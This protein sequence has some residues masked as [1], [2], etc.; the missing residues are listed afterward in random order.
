MT[1]VFRHYGRSLVLIVMC[2][3]LAIFL[4]GDV[5]GMRGNRGGGNQLNF[6]IGTAFGQSVYQRDL[7]R[8]EQDLLIAGAFGVGLP[9]PDG[10]DQ[11]ERAVCAYL[12]MEEARRAGVRFSL[13]EA[14]QHVNRFPPETVDNI[15]VHYSQSLEGMYSAVAR[16]GAALMFE[17][18]QAESVATE[19]A[20]RLE[21]FYRDQYQSAQCK[22]AAIDARGLLAAVPAPDDAE[23]TAHFEEA[24]NREDAHT[25]DALAF[26]YLLKDRV[27]LEFLT[28]DPK[29]C[30]NTIKV[31]DR[32]LQRYYDEHAAQRYTRPA[33]TS[34]PVAPNQPPPTELI[35]FAECKERVRADLRREKA[36]AEAQR[37]MNEVLHEAR[38]PWDSAA[39][40]EKGERQAPAASAQLSF[41]A[42]RAKFSQ[43]YTV[44]R[45]VTELEDATA[46]SREPGIGQSGELLNQRR[47]PISALA[48]RV[49]GIAT[50]TEGDSTP[51]LKLNEPKLAMTFEFSGRKQESYQFY[52]YRVVEAVAKGPPASLADVRD[53]AIENLKTRRAYEL[54]GEH[55]RKIAERA[56]TIGLEAAIAEDAELKT[57]LSEADAK[58]AAATQAASAPA[59]PAT[60]YAKSLEVRPDTPISRNTQFVPGLGRA[61]KLADQVFVDTTTQPALLPGEHRVVISQ[62]PR[63]FRW[64]L[65]EVAEIKPIYK[66]EFDARR[67][68]LKEQ[69]GKSLVNE[70]RRLWG[71]PQDI[72]R[73]TAFSAVNA[74]RAG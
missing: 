2:L 24:K 34:A 8:A 6:V 53:K 39:A 21:G 48:L 58:S 70:F 29:A 23:L 25:D 54:A 40:N 14:E 32:D 49:E 57:L 36:I 51:I 55:A 16:V 28:I 5:I 20:P 11:R 64:V 71:N 61:P 19:S 62:T 38:K 17:R 13:D 15:R 74:E 33:A 45:R 60:N 7:D 56:K 72:R 37:V 31:R 46:L 42:L 3:L 65:A 43:E 66:G 41:E 52:V 12:L 59:E 73:R 44:D 27:K 9:L 50:P 4:I 69:M 47:M 63:E 67:P 1:R 68:Q 10:I 35:P 18:Y 30:E 26:G 22:V